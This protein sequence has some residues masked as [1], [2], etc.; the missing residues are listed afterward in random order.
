VRWLALLSLLRVVH[1]DTTVPSAP[2]AVV[3]AVLTGGTAR[4]S[5]CRPD[6]VLYDD[7]RLIFI[8]HERYYQTRLAPAEYAELRAFF[9]DESFLSLGSFGPVETRWV[10]CDPHVDVR[11]GDDWRSVSTIWENLSAAPVAFLQRYQ[12]IVTFDHRRAQP[13]TPPAIQVVL[14]REL[15]G[16]KRYPTLSW[17]AIFPAEVARHHEWHVTFPVGVGHLAELEQLERDLADHRIEIN[18]DLYALSSFYG[19]DPP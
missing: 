15:P 19:H 9:S 5:I 10:A 13:W 18:G 3:R 1:A 14:R 8:K 16:Y 11:R 17:P 6:F 2:Q 4:F 12:R 7:R